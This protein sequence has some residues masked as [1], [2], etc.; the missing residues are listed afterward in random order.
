MA[1]P[2]FIPASTWV[3][4]EARNAE[5]QEQRKAA[6]QAKKE[7]D[8]HTQEQL[9]AACAMHRRLANHIG[10]TIHKLVT[11][12]KHTHLNNA[13]ATATI[14]GA[15]KGL[16][17]IQH[18]LRPFAIEQD[19]KNDTLKPLPLLIDTQGRTATGKTDRA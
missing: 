12:D 4:Y 5:R 11:K 18:S 19:N 1:R 8:P 2:S 6:R 17:G 7:K 10:G 16:S 9:W 3:H 14:A 13:I 15:A